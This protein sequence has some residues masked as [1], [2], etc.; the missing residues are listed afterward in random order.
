MSLKTHSYLF[1]FAISFGFFSCGKMGAYERSVV[2][3]DHKWKN[4]FVPEYTF[5]ITDTAALYRSFII[6]RHTH[7]YSYRNI[8][9]E[10]STRI[11]GDSTFR[12]DN[13]ELNLQQPDGRWVGTG[14][15]DILEVRYPLFSDL[16][17]KKPGN[18]TIRIKQIM[19]D[20]PLEHVMNAGIR[21]EK[22]QD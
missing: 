1:L 20:E 2:I 9:L 18:Y 14:F 5:E 4:S 6:L 19:R 16:R 3:P 8:W 15:S 12:S 21:V 17:F 22:I 7:A 13:F 11:P 10:L